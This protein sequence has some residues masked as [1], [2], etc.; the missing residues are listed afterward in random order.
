MKNLF[1]FQIIIMF[2]CNNN[3]AQV[4][5]FN[6]F[7]TFKLSPFNTEKKQNLVV[8]CNYKNEKLIKITFKDLKGK[9]L[10]SSDVI[11]LN[12]K[13][14]FITKYKRYNFFYILLSYVNNG[15]IMNLKFIRKNGFYLLDGF[16]YLNSKYEKDWRGFNVF[17]NMK[18]YSSIVKFIITDLDKLTVSKDLNYIEYF[19]Y[20]NGFFEYSFTQYFKKK[21]GTYNNGY[22]PGIEKNHSFASCFFLDS[23]LKECDY[24]T[25]TLLIDYPDRSK[26]P[27]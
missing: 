19:N 5:Y 3:F 6:N 20:H 11:Y 27:K 17:F 13:E 18:K 26:M 24:F 22:P 12:N 23:I 2:F 4:K 16:Y 1:F 25:D 21:D 9:E 7:D 14:F 15:K 8:K 10:L